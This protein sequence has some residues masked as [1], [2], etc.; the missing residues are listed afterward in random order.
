MRKHDPKVREYRGVSTRYMCPAPNEIGKI[1]GYWHT[2]HVS[3]YEPHF[4][5]R[6][7]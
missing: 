4:A 3:E 5:A 2:S 6:A 7:G 1:V